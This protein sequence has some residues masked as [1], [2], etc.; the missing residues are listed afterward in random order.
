[1]KIENVCKCNR[2]GQAQIIWDQMPDAERIK[3]SL[4]VLDILVLISGQKCEF[5]LYEHYQFFVNKCYSNTES[6]AILV[7]IS[8][9]KNE[10][11]S[12]AMDCVEYVTRLL[13][14]CSLDIYYQ[15]CIVK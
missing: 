11:G 12:V 13:V 1:M 15:K 6:C 2:S 4:R 3:C 7:N 9:D 8:W 14:R 10:K 5:A